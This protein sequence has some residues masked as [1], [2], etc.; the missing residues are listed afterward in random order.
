MASETVC[1][2]CGLDSGLGIGVVLVLTEI[3]NGC[4]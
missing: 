4:I 3:G 1:T 2:D